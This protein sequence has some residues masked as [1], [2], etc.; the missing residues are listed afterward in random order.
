MSLKAFH[1]V[2]ITLAVI[3]VFGFSWWCL[4][5]PG[6]ESYRLLGFV[7]AAF[8]AGLLGYGVW[9]YRKINTLIASGGLK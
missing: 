2:F 5:A 6:A 4:N 3:T 9:F 8:G 7:S 1:I